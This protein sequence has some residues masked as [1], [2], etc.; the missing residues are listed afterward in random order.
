MN[1][2]RKSVVDPI[3]G[4]EEEEHPQSKTYWMKRIFENQN[5]S[6]L[7]FMMATYG[8][9]GLMTVQLIAL[10]IIFKTEYMVEPA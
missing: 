7:Y 3:N 2:K 8:A 5:R 10:Q 6:M 4:A 9:D 1:D